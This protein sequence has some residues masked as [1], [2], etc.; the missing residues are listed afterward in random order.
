MHQFASGSSGTRRS[1]LWF[2]LFVGAVC[3]WV[4]SLPLFPTQDGPMHRY[5]AHALGAVLAH[6]PAFGVYQVRHPFP[7]YATQYI[8]LLAL[9]HIFSFDLAERVFTCLDILCFACGFRL[10]A[11]AVGA[12]G[13]WVSLL[14]VPLLLPWYLL[15]GFF[16][17]SIG[18][19]VALFAVGFWLRLDRGLLPLA[20]FAVSTF[21]LIFSHPVPLLLLL[22]FMAADLLRRRL[23]LPAPS[24]PWLRANARHLAAFAYALCLSLYPSLAIDKSQASS[25][26]SDLRFHLPFMRTVLLLTGVSPYNTRSHGLLV[27]GYRL[28]VYALLVIALLWGWQAFRTSLT[29]R[30]LS[31]GAAFFGYAVLFAILLPVMPDHLNGGVFFATR[32]VVMVWIFAL[33]AAAGRPAAGTPV[34]QTCIAL[35]ALFTLLTLLPAEHILRPIAQSL[36][37]VEQAAVPAHTQALLLNGPMLVPMSRSD[38]DLAFDP[39]LWSNALPLVRQDDLIVNAPWLPLSISPLR[40]TPG[41]PIQA[42][43][44]AF[45]AVP[46]K[47]PPQRLDSLFSS[48]EAERMVGFSSVILYAGTGS[49]LQA[50]LAPF[51]GAHDAAHFTCNRIES[52]S[53]ACVRSAR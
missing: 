38:Y 31:P 24:G 53:L 3:L 44:T 15:M 7:P 33:L 27:N 4:L 46:P 19:G 35:G 36:H 16:N 41:A 25:T 29:L 20:G 43:A 9:F 34:P 10:C 39:F 12:A 52:W 17:Y 13:A 8:S 14:I 6:Q 30:Q 40:G 2:A 48:A 49:E 32:M 28:A 50:G 18:I 23:F 37:R 22:V 51:L 45:T 1:G 21:V 26:L 11:T 47:D 42:D 5:Y